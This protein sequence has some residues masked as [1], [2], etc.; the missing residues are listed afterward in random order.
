MTAQPAEHGH[1]EV[2]LDLPPMNTVQEL[3]A[4]L[5]AGHGYPGDAERLDAELA[6]QLLRR[7][8]VDQLDQV[9]EVGTVVDLVAVAE[10]V[11]AYRGRVLLAADREA[12]DAVNEAVADL[13]ARQDAE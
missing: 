9:G 1:G 8:P 4:A 5:R 2:H 6:E 13:L 11:A 3:R 12:A 7:V 10:I